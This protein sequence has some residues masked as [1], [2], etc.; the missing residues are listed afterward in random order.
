MFGISSL[1]S[2]R[3]T[4]KGC[5]A[6]INEQLDN[7]QHKV[8]YEQFKTVLESVDATRIEDRLF[9]LEAFLSTEEHL[10]LADLKALLVDEKPELC[11]QTFLKETM[12][13]F[14]KF[15]FA[16]EIAFD[17]QESRYEHH[18][19][20]THHDHFICT[21]CGK[22]QEFNNQKLEKMQ[23]DIAQSIN[24][25]P[26][27]HRMEIYGLCSGCM[28]QRKKT[29]PLLMAANGEKVTIVKIDGGRELQSRLASMGITLDSC[30]DIINNNAIG[31]VLIA[32]DGVRLA[33]NRGMAQKILVEHACHH[34]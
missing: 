25:H 10:C 20:G 29:L 31:Q 3:R 5:K 14:C 32:V 18:H 22:I 1:L 8:E 34:R 33:L 15:G 28:A 4:D 12:D 7:E 11:D 19:L 27:Q 30:V 24:F 2:G 16:N 9:V 26:L 23:I 21:R 13:L 6:G 17:T